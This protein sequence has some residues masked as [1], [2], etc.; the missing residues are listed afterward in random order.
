MEFNFFSDLI[1]A[2]GKVFEGVQKVSDFTKGQRAEYYD[3]M[4]EA[5]QLI[6]TTLSMVIIRLGDILEASKKDDFREEVRALNNYGDW[7]EVERKFRLCESLRRSVR[8]T[9]NLLQKMKGKVSTKDWDDL[10]AL[11]YSTIATEGEV[12]VFISDQFNEIA[13][14]EAHLEEQE[15]RNHIKAFRKVLMDERKDLMRQ[16]VG[17]YDLI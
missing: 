17:M 4:S 6:N 3:V 9:K 13:Q 10:L 12:A 8:E 11:M 15:L 5:Y 16:E 1:K 2:L 7:I 14:K